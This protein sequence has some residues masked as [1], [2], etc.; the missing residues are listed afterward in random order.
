VDL[1]LRYPAQPS[2]LAY[3]RSRLVSASA[4][5]GLEGPLDGVYPPIKDEE[6]L[7]RETEEAKLLGCK[8][9]MLIHPAQIAAVNELF[10]PTEEQVEEARQMLDVYQKAQ[11][12]GKGAIQWQGKMLDEPALKWAKRVLGL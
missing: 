7:R 11:A 5:A 9:K 10:T 12:E 1:E 3:A 2:A 4:A 6:G 8:G